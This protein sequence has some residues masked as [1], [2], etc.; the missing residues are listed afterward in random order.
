MT[1]EFHH[2]VPPC[3]AISGDVKVSLGNHTLSDGSF[4]KYSDNLLNDLMKAKFKKELGNA[5]THRTYD[6]T[7]ACI[8]AD[9]VK[10]TKSTP[11]KIVGGPR[12][13][14]EMKRIECDLKAA[15][16]KWADARRIALEQEAA[17]AAVAQFHTGVG[18]PDSAST[19]QTAFV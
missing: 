12:Q 9:K 1:I 3:G 2:Q 17:T 11:T 7:R 19:S 18:D 15:H 8:C 6:M 13:T 16:K 4:L 10:V 5:K 14:V